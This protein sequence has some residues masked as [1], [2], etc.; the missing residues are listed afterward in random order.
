MSVSHFLSKPLKKRNKKKNSKI[1]AAYNSGQQIQ[2]SCSSSHYLQTSPQ[3]VPVFPHISTL[4]LLSQK[5]IC[6]F[7]TAAQ[8]ICFYFFFLKKKKREKR[9]ISEIIFH[10]WIC[11]HMLS[12][13][14]LHNK[15]FIHRRQQQHKP[16]QLPGPAT[17]MY[18]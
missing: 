14:L 2:F 17:C 11:F 12:G 4:C 5:V 13:A 10:F 18:H 15:H 9:S 1:R 3:R 6:T 8:F 7:P 16:V